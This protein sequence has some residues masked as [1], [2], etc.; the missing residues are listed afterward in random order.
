MRNRCH[1]CL[2][3]L[4]TAL[5][6][7]TIFS[8]CSKDPVREITK[9]PPDDTSQ[10]VVTSFEKGVFIINEG[11]YNWG[12]A[13]VTFFDQKTNKVV[14]DVFN[15]VNQRTLGDVAESMSIAG[16]NGYLMINNSNRIEVVAAENFKSV[17]T[18]NG[19]HS[20]RFMTMAGP[21]KAY[22]TNLQS[23]I[24]IIDLNNH[25]VTGTIKTSSWTEN[26][27]SYQ[28]YVLVTSIGSF[29]EPSSGRK[30]QLFLI[31]TR[32]DRIID[33]I[34]T[35]KEPIG[36]VIDKKDKVWVLCSGG[37]DSFESPSLMRIN[38]ELRM[39][40]KVFTFSDPKLIPSRLCINATGDT[41]YFLRQGVCRMAVSDNDLPAQPLI[42]SEGRLLY[43]LA[44]Q[45]STG[46][47]FTSDAIDYVQTGKVYQYRQDGTLIRSFMA[48]RIPGSFC[49]IGE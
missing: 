22:V 1:F 34:Q 24:S 39:V 46:Y 43:G 23:N 16:N 26:M 20:P 29:S 3:Y 47:I 18:I 37:Y 38:P 25:T 48:G 8:G 11:N 17:A 27:I 15:L 40:E 31:D 41:M 44:V 7:L 13:S 28:H 30:A 42:P 32:T 12:N 2:P 9:T 14:H 33:S 19:L 35:G 5:V 45:P 49:F 36:M 6:A 21:G 4:L 10:T